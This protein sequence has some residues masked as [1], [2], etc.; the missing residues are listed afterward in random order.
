MLWN[1][2]NVFKAIMVGLI[3]FIKNVIPLF[4]FAFLGL[5]II[6]KVFYVLPIS[7]TLWPELAFYH[8]SLIESMNENLYDN[9]VVSIF[10]FKCVGGYLTMLIFLLANYIIYQ[11]CIKKETETSA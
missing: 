9:F 11:N 1:N 5:V 7:P 10:I 6:F 8:V 4:T 2:I 3:A